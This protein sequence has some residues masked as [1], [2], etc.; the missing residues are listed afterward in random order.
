VISSN[1]Q[2]AW[3]EVTVDLKDYR[4]LRYR[5]PADSFGNVAEIEF[6]RDGQKESGV[7][8]GTPGSWN[9]QG[10]SF[11]RVFDENV[12][13]FFDA[14]IPTGAY[15]GIDTLGVPPLGSHSLQVLNGSGTGVYPVG[16]VVT[17][18]ANPLPEGEEFAGWAG[19]ISVLADPSLPTTTATVP[20][21]NVSLTAT[22]RPAT[23][24]VIFS[25]RPGHGQRMLGGI[26]EGHKRRSD[27]WSL[28]DGLYGQK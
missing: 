13:T 26:F 12:N 23:D 10:N 15:A 18:R 28:R 7:T 19:D 27:Q 3:N 21:G 11:H 24:A 16:T 5:A 17:V 2:L 6:Y 9:D 25:P 22:S 20:V 1:P 8:F 4:Y 14:L